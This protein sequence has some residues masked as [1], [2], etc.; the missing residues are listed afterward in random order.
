MLETDKENDAT[1]YLRCSVILYTSQKLLH[2]IIRYNL[3][4]SSMNMTQIEKCVFYKKAQQYI[5]L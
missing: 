2:Y 1:F 4:R 5:A 3:W